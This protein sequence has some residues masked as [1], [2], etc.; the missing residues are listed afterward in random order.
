M[1]MVPLGAPT[2]ETP[3]VG[4]VAGLEVEPALTSG[5][6]CGLSAMGLAG[7]VEVGMG[8]AEVVVAGVGAV[9]VGV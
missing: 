3:G 6:T 2:G 8:V 7:G 4:L 5:L 9:A 1:G